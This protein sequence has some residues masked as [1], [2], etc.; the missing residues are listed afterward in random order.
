MLKSKLTLIVDGNWLLMSRLSVVNNKYVDDIDLCHN[1]KLMM[2]KSIE[3]VLRTFKDIDNIIFVAD[4]GSWRNKVEIPEFM[5]Q[6]EEANAEYK[7]TREKSQDIN[8][9][10]I[11]TAYD[12]FVALLKQT[13]ITSCKEKDVEGDDWCYFWS[14]YLNSI[15]TNCIIWSK[16]N[17]LKQLVK[18]DKNKCF[19]AWWNKDNGL[20]VEDIDENELSFLFNN[21]FS[22][23]ESLMTGLCD[24]SKDLHKISPNHIIIDKII[25][26]DA[27]DNILPVLVREPKSGSTRKFRVSSKDI[28]YELDYNDKKSVQSYFENLLSQKSYAGRVKTTI[29]NILEHFKYNK[30]L[31][32][33]DI[34]SYPQYIKDI[35]DMHKDDYNV[36]KNIV[37]AQSIIQA[38]N[39]K[40]NGILDL[41]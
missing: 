12:D 28:D 24:K 36:S 23:N 16:D 39:N 29:D 26:G 38:S 37:E 21:E 30:Q 34:S 41:L 13:G 9:D 8:W 10:M 19:T 18:T 15:G 4:G 32:L 33:L 20:Y 5:Q 6:D 31:V 35:F 40:L 14:R 25:R 2:I 27:S 11:F 17:D 3:V 7:G 22:A 1:L